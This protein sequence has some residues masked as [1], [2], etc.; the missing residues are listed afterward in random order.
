MRPAPWQETLSAATFGPSCLQYSRITDTVVGQEDC[1]Y[2]NVY[3]PFLPKIPGNPN[4]RTSN[5]INPFSDNISSNTKEMTEVHASVTNYAAICVSFEWG[6]DIIVTWAPLMI[7]S[8]DSTP[9]F[10]IHCASKA[11]DYSRST[12]QR[13]L[14]WKNAFCT[15]RYLIMFQS[16]YFAIKR[17]QTRPDVTCSVKCDACVGRPVHLF[18]A[19]V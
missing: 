19:N 3:T 6:N 12:F 9:H 14:Q 13:N 4:I 18:I 17:R 2:L 7:D 5:P 15:W 16:H 8:Q 10:T 11:A 1:L